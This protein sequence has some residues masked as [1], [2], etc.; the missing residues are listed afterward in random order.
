[1]V[2]DGVYNTKRELI[3]NLENLTLDRVCKI[4]AGAF[5]RAITYKKIEK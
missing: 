2:S 1:M 5:E 3:V 4:V